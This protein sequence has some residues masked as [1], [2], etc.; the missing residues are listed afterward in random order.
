MSQN[1][2]E[3]KITDTK[4]VAEHVLEIY[5]FLLMLLEEG[6]DLLMTGHSKDVRGFLFSF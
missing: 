3:S 4:N 5:S 2:F 6:N 1:P